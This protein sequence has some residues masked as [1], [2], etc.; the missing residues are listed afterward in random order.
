MIFFCWLCDPGKSSAWNL[1]TNLGPGIIK[2][3]KC[4]YFLMELD[5]ESRARYNQQIVTTL[6]DSFF[7]FFGQKMM[8]L[9]ELYNSQLLIEKLEKREVWCFLESMIVTKI[10]ISSL[11]IVLTVWLTVFEELYFFGFRLNSKKLNI[12]CLISKKRIDKQM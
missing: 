10:K 2:K 3:S 12:H 1:I 7:N 8:E 9:Q 4:Y 11:L 5:N 6:T